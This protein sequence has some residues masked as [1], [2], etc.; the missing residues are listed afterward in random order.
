MNQKNMSHGDGCFKIT[1][2]KQIAKD[3]IFEKNV[4]VFHPETITIASN[5]YI[6]HNTILKGYHKNEMI[7]GQNTW[8]G[9]NCF[10]HSAGGLRI[11]SS[12]GIGPCVKIITSTHDDKDISKPV[13]NNEIRF[14]QVIIEDGSDIGIGSII[15]PGC[16]I[17]TKAIIGAGSVVTGNIPDYA[18]AAGVPARILRYRKKNA[19]SC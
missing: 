2:F 9:Q 4:L 17:G 1:E 10:F 15:M 8:I 18:V 12:V 7:I 16:K 13:L 19:Y 14:G 5:V 3:V 6:G 11:G